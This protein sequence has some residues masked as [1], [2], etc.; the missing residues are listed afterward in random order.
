MAS[1]KRL[2]SVVLV[3]LVLI[4]VAVLTAPARAASPSSTNNSNNSSPT[5]Y[6]PVL[7]ACLKDI[8]LP[9]RFSPF[10]MDAI[11]ARLR[12]FS[13][14]LLAFG[15]AAS[16]MTQ[17]QLQINYAQG[18]WPLMKCLIANQNSRCPYSQ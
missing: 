7:P 10:E 2:C 18:V 6:G 4:L 15:A 13:L 3:P 9:H 17:D 5:N 12:G 8:S 1:M 16:T 14:E 11:R